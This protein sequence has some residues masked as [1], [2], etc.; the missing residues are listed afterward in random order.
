M[1]GDRRDRAEGGDR[2]R[3]GWW[4]RVIPAAAAAAFSSFPLFLAIVCGGGAFF[5]FLAALNA[6]FSPLVWDTAGQQ[7]LP[8]E[9]DDVAASIGRR[10]RFGSLFRN[11]AA[12]EPEVLA[13]SVARSNQ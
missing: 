1:T 9:G 2:R 13:C 8:E 5:V 3:E 11:K 7:L 4:C 6:V 12:H 10:Q